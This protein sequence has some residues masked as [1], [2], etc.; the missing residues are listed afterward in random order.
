M[1]AIATSSSADAGLARATR[2][3]ARR[4]DT[5]RTVETPEGCVLELRVAGPFARARA[6]LLDFSVRTVIYMAAASAFSLLGAFGMGLFL[7]FAFLLEWG[8][9][10]AFEIWRDGQTPGKRMCGLAVVHDEGTPVGAGASVTRNL[11]RAV[12]FLPVGYVTGAIAMLAAGDGRRLGDLAAGTLVVH[13]DIPSGLA[14]RTWA[15]SGSAP[16]PLPLSA[17][18][19][20]AVVD[21]AQRFTRLSS[22]RAEELAATATPLVG[23]ARGTDAVTRLLQMANGILGVEATASSVGEHVGTARGGLDDQR[24]DDEAHREPR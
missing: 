17:R 21:F 18:E 15:E 3:Q 23:T 10:V 5:V 8:Y 14:S 20:R 22:A 4:I 6:W 24:R 7:V 12:D 13:V 16:P 11:M 1:P 2:A 9:P 19:R